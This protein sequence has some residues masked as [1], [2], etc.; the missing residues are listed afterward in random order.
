MRTSLPVCG[1]Q[2]DSFKYGGAITTNN[3]PIAH[4][5]VKRRKR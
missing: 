2:K 3:D 1:K 4:W 5:V